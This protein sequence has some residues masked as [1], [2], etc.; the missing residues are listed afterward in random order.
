MV[1]SRRSRA[2]GDDESGR[3]P[4]PGRRRAA[5]RRNG[6]APASL[7]PA[8]HP[9]EQAR[10]VE[11]HDP[12]AVEPFLPSRVGA[13]DHPGDR[14]LEA[15]LL[16]QA[17]LPADP[18]VV[19]DAVADQHESPPAARGGAGDRQARVEGNEPARVLGPLERR[20][21]GGWRAG[22]RRPQ[23]AGDRRRVGGVDQRRGRVVAEGAAHLGQ[24]GGDRRHSGRQVLEDLVG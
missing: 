9:P 23:G 13:G 15:D 24:V 8:Q 20:R 6:R 12:D 19:G 3:P 5:P 2:P 17:G 18:R 7:A 1:A 14:H 16:E 21:D 11:A 10:R 4:A 22:D